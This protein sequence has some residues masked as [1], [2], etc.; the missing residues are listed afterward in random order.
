MEKCAGV[1]SELDV[2]DRIMTGVSMQKS[3]LH[4]QVPAMTIS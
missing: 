2:F 1:T 4:S 3:K